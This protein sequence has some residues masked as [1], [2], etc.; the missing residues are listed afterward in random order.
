MISKD[1]SDLS[2]WVDEDGSLIYSSENPLID[3]IPA[4]NIY[5]TSEDILG[6]SRPQNA[7]GDIGAAE[8]EFAQL[9]TFTVDKETE[10]T[11]ASGEELVFPYAI[12]GEESGVYDFS[13]NWSAC[14]AN[15]KPLDESITAE[16]LGD[17]QHEW[18]NGETSL[19]ASRSIIFHSVK[20]AD[21]VLTVVS[22][23]NPDLIKTFT[24]HVT[25]DPIQYVENL[26]AQIQDVDAITLA[27][28]E[29]INSISKR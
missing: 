15:G 2:S 6:I 25:G 19:S 3:Q 26:I 24:I 21:V 5:L 23:A 12:G 4:D 20:N 13:L 22:N 27:D 11:A 28:K 29:Q 1:Y 10:L 16:G 8:F 9:T 17:D 7:K 18:Q 14:Y